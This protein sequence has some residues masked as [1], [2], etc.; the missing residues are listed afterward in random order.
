MGMFDQAALVT[1][2]NFCRGFLAIFQIESLCFFRCTQ[3]F[4]FQNVEYTYLPILGRPYFFL[5]IYPILAVPL[6]EK[7]EYPSYLKNVGVSDYHF[8]PLF[9]YS[10]KLY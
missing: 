9:L 2:I 1:Q 8:L 4:P 10:V 7:H 6:K 5:N 3:L